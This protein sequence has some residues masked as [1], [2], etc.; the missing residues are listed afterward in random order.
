MK[1]WIKSTIKNVTPQFLLK[2]RRQQQV[3]SL[4]KSNAKKPIKDVFTGIYEQHQWGGSSGSYCSGSGST[5]FHAAL[6]AEMINNLIADKNIATMVDLGCGDFAVGSQIDRKR[7]NYIG[8]DI[9]ENLIEFNIG[10]FSDEHTSFVCLN[11]VENVLPDGD[12]C[13]IRQVLQH[14]SNDEI[15]IILQ[16]VG[17]YKYVLVTEHYPAPNIQIRPNLDKVHGADTRI[18]DGS[19]VYLDKPPF[20]IPSE[21]I[22]LVLDVEAMHYLECKGERIKTFLL[23]NC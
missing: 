15:S 17:K 3:K 21:T 23:E 16:K 7:I 18:V 19:A 11:A 14:L 1:T 6:Y 8:I 5:P 22:K 20:N 12:L 2:L 4:R 13:A 10:R 9:V